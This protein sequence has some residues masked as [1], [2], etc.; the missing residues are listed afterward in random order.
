MDDDLKPL[1]KKLNERLLAIQTIVANKDAEIRA[2]HDHIS[3]LSI[4]Q[5]LLLA[6]S[7]LHDDRPK[8]T[9]LGAIEDLRGLYPDNHHLEAELNVLSRVLS[10]NTSRPD[11]R[12]EILRWVPKIIPG[13]KPRPE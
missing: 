4:L 12:S 8:E 10:G 2:L 9:I 6:A 1:V 7:L 3:A 13:G 5:K 11:F